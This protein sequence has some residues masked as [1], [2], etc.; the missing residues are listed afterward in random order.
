MTPFAKKMGNMTSKLIWQ[1]SHKGT[2]KDKKTAIA[3]YNEHIEEVKALVPE[4]RLLIFSV[5][6]GWEPLC[7]FLGVDVANSEFP[8]VNDRTQIKKSIADIT[9]GAYTFIAIGILIVIGL[10]YTITRYLM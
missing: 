5:D 2:M 9:K 7:K 1:R 6:Q 8:N 4:D 10:I 3:R